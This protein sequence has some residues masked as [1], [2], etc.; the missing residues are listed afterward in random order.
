MPT[1]RAPGLLWDA[2]FRWPCSPALPL[3]LRHGRSSSIVDPCSS[4]GASVSVSDLSAVTAVEALLNFGRPRRALAEVARVTVPG[5]RLIITKRDDRIALLL[6]WKD[7]TSRRLER[8]TSSAW[9]RDVLAIQ[10]QR[11]WQR[12][13]RSDQAAAGCLSQTDRGHVRAG[14]GDLL[15]GSGKQNM[16]EQAPLGA[17]GC[18]TSGELSGVRSVAQCN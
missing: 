11:P 14:I 5:G 17:R 13:C 4:R 16:P 7:F 1:H 6:P 18:P 3:T 2:T 10:R 9:R 8:A 15:T 12:S